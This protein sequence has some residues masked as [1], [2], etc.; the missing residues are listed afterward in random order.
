MDRDDAGQGTAFAGVHP[1]ETATVT[2]RDAII[3][4]PLLGFRLV[5]RD[6]SENRAMIEA[7]TIP[8]A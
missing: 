5:A 7:L 2:D 8:L 4:N 1:P 6:P 3:G